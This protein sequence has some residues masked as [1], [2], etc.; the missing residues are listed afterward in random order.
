MKR[1]DEIEQIG[2]EAAMG[3][4]RSHGRA[5]Q[6]VSVENLGFD[7]RSSD[8]QGNLRYIEV[9]A[10]ARAGPVELTQNE[11]FKAHSLGES[12][13]LYVVMSA[14]STVP[15]LRIYQNPAAKLTME[16][17]IERRYTVQLEELD[18]ANSVDGAAELDE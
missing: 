7:I 13:F 2:M 17:R 6:D 10:R 1:D 9:K 11:V 8:D 12:Y 16:E 5:P 14:A 18:R 4:E 3:H 15:A